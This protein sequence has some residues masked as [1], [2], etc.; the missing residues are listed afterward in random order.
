M[1]LE[2]HHVLCVESPGLLLQSFSCEVLS[3]GA[4]LVVKYEEQSFGREFVEEL[5]GV[6]EGRG[7]RV[8]VHSTGYRCPLDVLPHTL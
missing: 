8:V 6:E 4:F 1:S 3:L 7:L 2:P 5:V